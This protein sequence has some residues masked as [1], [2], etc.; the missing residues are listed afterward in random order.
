[1]SEG[2]IKLHRE[3]RSH[4][5]WDSKPFSYGQAWTDLLM[6]VNHKGNKVLMD[7]RL[8]DVATGSVITSEAKLSD[9]WGWSRTKTRNFLKLLEADGMIERIT[10]TK[11]TTI[12]IVNWAKYQICETTEEPQRDSKKTVEKHQKNI[13]KNDSTNLLKNGKKG[14]APPFVKPTVDEVRDYI[15]EQGY[16]VSAEQFVNWYEANGWMVGRNKMK[17]WQ[18]AVRNWE[19]REKKEKQTAFNSFDQRTYDY[20]DLTE[21]LA[22]KG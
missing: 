19:Q 16:H 18:A 21:R 3:M 12:N 11:K 2:W 6:M 9:M 4:W 10:D 5:L 8:V 1:M 7:H 20:D 15:R 17:S 13:N 22:A 14:S